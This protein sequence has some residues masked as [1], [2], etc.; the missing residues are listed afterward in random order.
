MYLTGNRSCR[1][2]LISFSMEITSNSV[3]VIYSTTLWLK[4]VSH[5]DNKARVK[6]IKNGLN[7]SF[8][9]PSMGNHN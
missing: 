2:N 6:S 8:F 4:A 1:T 5:S 3:D 7:T 9:N